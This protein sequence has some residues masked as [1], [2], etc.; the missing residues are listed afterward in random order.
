[1]V[2]KRSQDVEWDYNGRETRPSQTHSH[3]LHV[4]SKGQFFFFR[5]LFR[6]KKVMLFL[7]Q[8]LSISGRTVFKEHKPKRP[9]SNIPTLLYPDNMPKP[10]PSSCLVRH[11]EHMSRGWKRRAFP[12]SCSSY[13][14]SWKWNGLPR[15]H[16]NSLKLS[17]VCRSV[18]QSGMS[19]SVHVEGTETY[20]NELHYILQH[21]GGMSSSTFAPSTK[22]LEACWQWPRI[23]AAPPSMCKHEHFKRFLICKDP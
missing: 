3:M 8:R 9:L 16:Y 19:C 4:G 7:Q 12:T 11:K 6:E 2:S 5:A 22:G 21:K 13:N 15:P 1:M 23:P 10:S 20:E 18:C 17:Q 14:R